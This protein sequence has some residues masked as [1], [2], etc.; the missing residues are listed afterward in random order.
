MLRL[1]TAAEQDLRGDEAFSVAVTDEPWSQII[2]TLIITNDPH[3]PLHYFLLNGLR[4]LVGD[5][6]IAL[7]VSSVWLSLILLALTARVGFDVAGRS[8]GLVSMLLLAISQSQ[9][10]I[11]QDV[12]NQYLLALCLGM[13]ATL[14]LLRRRSWWLYI[15]AAT[16]AIYSHYF[17]IFILLAHGILLLAAPERRRDLWGWTAAGCVTLV[18][19]IPWLTVM[20]E[21]V[22]ATQLSSPVVVDLGEH[23]VRVGTEL[24]VGSALPGAGQR[25]VFLVGLGLVWRAVRHWPNGGKSMRDGVPAWLVSWLGLVLLGLF[26]IRLNR[27]IYNDFY[28]VMAAPAWALLLGAGI[29]SLIRRPRKTLPVGTRRQIRF[30]TARLSGASALILI[31]GANVFSLRNYF[32]DTAAFGRDRGYK[33]IAALLATEADTDDLLLFNAPDPSLGYYLRDLPQ[34]ESLQPPAIGLT[35]EAINE[36]VA[37]QVAPYARVWFVPADA[38]VYDPTRA[39]KR[40]LDYHMLHEQYD[41]F[42]SLE[43]IAY[44]PV[45][46]VAAVAN[47][48]NVRWAAALD[49][50]GVYLTRNGTPVPFDAPLSLTPG[51]E[52]AVTLLWRATATVES[53]FA[54]FVHL[55]SDAGQLVGQHDGIPLF[56]TRP[57]SS[58]RRGE[59]LLDRHVLIVGEVEADANVRLV[60]GFYMPTNVERVPTAA[61]ETALVVFPEAIAV[62]T[63]SVDDE[64]DR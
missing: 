32:A 43:I 10:W 63:G 36:S 27:A 3:P 11:G 17:G 23:L 22:V 19:F 1:Q 30:W 9:V 60:T 7:R 56:G 59:L 28:A 8:V 38:G 47:P 16:L 64:L 55:L 33:A 18:L 21:R 58:W 48:L 4:E 14:M 35:D 29:V 31:L 20:V 24:A 53:D 45:E 40:W 34:K 51:D 42:E 57:T 15:L 52:L 54:V 5:S 41:R 37:K 39:V 2:A 6:E 50:R 46:S 26:L 61:G 12:R 13:M 44:R 25:W 49:L 62:R